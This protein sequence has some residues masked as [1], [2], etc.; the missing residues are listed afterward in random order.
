MPKIVLVIHPTTERNGLNRIRA[1][2]TPN[3]LNMVCESAARFAEG[4]PTEA[5]MLAVMVVPIFSPRTI[6]QAIGNGIHP[7]L[8]IIRVI[9]IV[10]DDDWSTR[11]S[12]E[13]KPRKIRTDQ[14]PN[15]D[16][17]FTNSNT[18]GVCL[19]S[20]TESFMNERP[21]KRSEK[22]TTSSPMFLLWFFF[23]IDRMNPTSI[24]GTA[25]IEISALNP[26]HATIHAVTV[27]PMLAPMMTPI[28]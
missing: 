28:A 6:A 13:P 11:V 2:I 24:K 26:S 21:R 9:A 15:P 22:P 3:T 7:M 18:S 20:G 12:T 27:V 5:A 10:A 4:L 25:R 16:H 23:E 8:S 1:H 17:V 14:N 19:R